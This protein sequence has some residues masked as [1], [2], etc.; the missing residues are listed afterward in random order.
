MGVDIKV[1]TNGSDG[2]KNKLTANDIEKSTGIIIAA[3]RKK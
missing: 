2:V 1:E 3:D